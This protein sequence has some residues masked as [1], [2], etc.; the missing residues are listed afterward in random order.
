MKYVLGG[1]LLFILFILGLAKAA[2]KPAPKPT[3]PRA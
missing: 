2:G 1:V 3:D